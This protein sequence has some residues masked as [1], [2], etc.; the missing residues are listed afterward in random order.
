ML[1][2]AADRRRSACD[3]ADDDDDDDDDGAVTV[4]V[5]DASDGCKLVVSEIGIGRC[6][7]RRRE[8]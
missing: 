1:S 2:F 4:D 6:V 7:V 8:E 3:T 5:L